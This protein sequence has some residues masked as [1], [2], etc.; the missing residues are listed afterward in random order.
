VGHDEEHIV[1]AVADVMVDEE[2]A[3]PRPLHLLAAEVEDIGVR[4]GVA[5]V[6]TD[7]S[8]DDAYSYHT[9]TS[10]KLAVCL[11]PGN[12][13]PSSEAATYRQYCGG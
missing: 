8:L 6:A 11:E 2:A 1:A 12:R 5:D 4:G 7:V 10:A 3:L 13:E 9:N